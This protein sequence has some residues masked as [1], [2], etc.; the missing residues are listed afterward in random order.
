LNRVLAKDPADRFQSAQDLAS[1]LTGTPIDELAT[2]TVVLPTMSL[3]AN[4]TGL[5]RW[6]PLSLGLILVL[7]VGIFG[8]KMLLDQNLPTGFS[9]RDW[10]L[11]GEFKTTNDQDDLQSVLRE[12][13]VIDMQQSRYVNV[14]AGSRLRDALQ[15]MG[16]TADT[17]LS[18]ELCNELALR[19]S[20]PAVL[21][22]SI[23]R[24]GETFLL[25]AQVVVPSTGEALMAQRVEAQ[26][27]SE[28]LPAL[29]ELSRTI[30]ERLGESIGSIRTEDEP[31][32][33]V[34][35]ASLKAL[36]HF[37]QGN[38]AFL[39]SDWNSAL[40]LLNQAVAT[41]STFAMAYAK[42]A[43]IHF[44]NAN[45]RDALDYSELAYRWRERLT[46][47]ERL[48]IEG[49]YHR[50]R[51]QYDEAISN[52]EDLLALYPDDLESRNNLATTY[53]LTMQYQDALLELDKHD[54]GFKQTWYYH[55]A[56]GNTL[57]GLERFD[58]AAESFGLAMEI[59]PSR[60]RTRM[61]LSGSL[62]ASG[63]VSLAQ[64]HLDSM[65]ASAKGEAIGTDYLISKVRMTMGQFDL[66]M[67]SLT[68]AR[69][70][71]LALDNQNQVAWIQVYQGLCQNRQGQLKLAEQSFA[72][73]AEIWPGDYPLLYL[74]KVQARLG[75]RDAASNSRNRLADLYERE[76]TSSNK[77]FLLKLESEMARY[78]NDL[79]GAVSSLQQCLP[80]YMF[81]LDAHFTLGLLYMD[82]D[83]L[84][85]ARENFQFIVEHRY[86]AFLE[87]LG[88]LW[89]LAEYHLGLLAEREGQFE[90]AAHR[91]QTFLQIWS[92][93]DSGLAELQDATQRL[94]KLT[95][96]G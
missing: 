66:A 54:P 25:T 94:E 47:R 22:G 58:E 2:K 53:L 51:A 17:N 35:T 18:A 65:S 62:F 6:L 89:P 83:Q 81:N 7:L 44:F 27:E 55:H 42:L 80:Y 5:R 3:P 28:L 67:Q 91:Y 50:Y 14:F 24:L 19:E 92:T 82:L 34:T 49:E 76:S 9:E 46:Q 68:S 84:T 87:G 74:G 21:V 33:S 59:N 12:A 96:G 43:R 71:A 38:Q 23:N 32:A 8:G 10:L 56:R 1:A 64:V 90:E 79:P 75:K 61:C 37:S 4:R 16:K 20:I 39:A 78:Q 86:S 73:A 95:V 52:L 77:Q 57:S 63:Q 11:I 70:Q 30:R 48:Y 41:D 93:A 72:A 60:Q 69:S 85:L 88:F 45:T 29:D 13:L 15:R 36:R 26:G 40:T 31:L